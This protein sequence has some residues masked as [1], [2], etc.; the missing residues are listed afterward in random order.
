MKMI[1]I[2]FTATVVHVYC[3]VAIGVSAV[4]VSEGQIDDNTVVSKG[5]GNTN[6]DI[7]IT[8]VDG[9]GT[10]YIIIKVDS[11]A[12]TNDILG[13]KITIVKT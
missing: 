10:N 12:T 4:T 3:D 2:G 9:D 7:D 8:D 5:T 6:A 11:A 13:G 1:P